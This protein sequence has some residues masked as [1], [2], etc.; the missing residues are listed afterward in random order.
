MDNPDL[1]CG[2]DEAFMLQHM[3][4]EKGK[5]FGVFHGD[6]LISFAVVAF[7]GGNADNLGRDVIPPLK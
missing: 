7:P 4:K 3:Q 5:V 1:Y 6:T 2:D